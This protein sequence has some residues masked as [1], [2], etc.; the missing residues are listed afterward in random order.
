MTANVSGDDGVVLKQHKCFF[1]YNMGV[2]CIFSSDRQERSP[3]NDSGEKT[4]EEGID[5][6]CC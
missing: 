2:L 5:K 6:A 1:E 3:M 4:K